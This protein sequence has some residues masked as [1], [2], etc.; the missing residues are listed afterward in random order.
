M[1]AKK[2]YKKINLDEVMIGLSDE[3]KSDMTWSVGDHKFHVSILDA[4]T[5]VIADTI[6]EKLKDFAE[7]SWDEFMKFIENQYLG[8]GNQL[9]LQTDLISEIKGSVFDIK[10]DIG[11]LKTKLDKSNKQL[12]NHETRIKILEEKVLIIEKKINI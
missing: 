9:K 6:D 10:R 3:T 4:H 12:Y 5:Q 11:M 1:T 2:E 8:I 7:G